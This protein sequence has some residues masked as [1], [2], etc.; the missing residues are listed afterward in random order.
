MP[1]ESALITAEERQVRD[2]ASIYRP[3]QSLM[4]DLEERIELTVEGAPEFMGEALAHTLK[5]G[6]KRLRPA[7]TLLAATFGRDTPKG[8]LPMATAIELLHT[9]TLVHDDTID[10]ALLRRGKLTANRLW[11]SRQALLI[12]DYL[13]AASA[14]ITAETGNVQVMKLYSGMLADIC[15]GAMV[16]YLAGYPHSRR[17]YFRTVDRKTASL[18][19]AAAESGALM[20]KASPATVRALRSYGHNLGMSFQVV[21]DIV[22]VSSDLSRGIFN[23]PAIVFLELPENSWVRDMLARNEA[24]GARAIME[25][26]PRSAVIE[27]C[28]SVARRF[29]V[30]AC[31][32]ISKLPRN[33]AYQSLVDLAWFLIERET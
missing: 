7:V 22:D 29:S 30:R 4:E 33:G 31:H 28:Y 32:S 13:C 8:S 2:V 12:G 26:V 27:D 1:A 24:E 19:A 11:G 21:D 3:I 14:H 23:L 18:F 15:E 10:S 9:A 25:E 6:G 20:S 5:S 17:D 16:E